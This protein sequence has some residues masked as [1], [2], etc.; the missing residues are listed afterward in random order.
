MATVNIN[1]W[2]TDSYFFYLPAAA[3]LFELPYISMI[4]SL[5]DPD[6]LG[7]IAM[8]GKEA[9]VLG[10]AVMQKLLH[11]PVSLYP[12]ILL[13]VWATCCSSILIFLITRH[14]FDTA[15][16]LIAFVLFAGSFWP[17]MYV[18]QG[19]HQPLVV[20][21]FLLTAYFLLKAQ[22]HWVF[23]ALAG[24]AGGFMMFSSPTAVLYLPYFGLCLFLPDARFDW[25][26]QLTKRALTQTGV[27]ALGFSVVFLY[28]TLPDPVELAREFMRFVHYSRSINHFDYH[29]EALKTIFPAP[30]KFNLPAPV[31]FRGG[32]WGWIIKYFMLIMPLL[33]PAYLACA[34][35]LIKIGAGRRRFLGAVLISL[36]TPIAVEVAQVSQFGRSYFSWI[37]GIIYL[38]VYTF[39]YLKT[40]PAHPVPQNRRRLFV[41]LTAIFLI[42][43]V[44][45]NARIF[46]SDV[47]P[48]RMG[49]TLAR[50]WIDRHGIEHISVYPEHMNNQ[51]T[52]GVLS[53]PRLGPSLA[54]G[55]MKS[56]R[57]I[58]E[59]Y[60]FIPPLTGKNIMGN[61]V[62]EDFAGDP[63]L[64]ELFESGQIERFAVA[65]FPTLAS[66]RIWLQEEEICAYRDLIV[67]Q[68]SREDLNLRG[69]AYIL[70]AR[71][72]QDT[73][74]LK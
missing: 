35:C 61:C 27:F 69:R 2:P 22:R 50:T 1:Y 55:N 43:Y 44:A 62:D 48:A 15:A 73:W 25:R 72:L 33:F 63:A 70:D 30:Y 46:L 13:L 37:I 3:K 23:C 41:A 53:T 26:S 74:F 38:V 59:G 45:L 32:G 57:D 12:N 39:Y 47:F 18:L 24:A 7:R 29:H 19:A 36:S 17:Y 31:S 66:S 71:Q 28:F 54:Y 10:I 14:L 21:F 16:A 40:K 60:L 51:V 42:A 5:P 11:D 67:G 20:M 58:K 65:S 8:H 56:I 4:H 34:A 6:S 52:A 64:T 49:S 68:I 9:L